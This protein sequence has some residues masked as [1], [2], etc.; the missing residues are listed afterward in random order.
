VI[1]KACGS[2]PT[3]GAITRILKMV[4]LAVSAERI[5]SV[6]EAR[7]AAYLAGSKARLVGMPLSTMWVDMPALQTSS[8]MWGAVVNGYQGT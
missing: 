7:T 8:A 3:H 2:H 1:G 6:C 4:A 5:G